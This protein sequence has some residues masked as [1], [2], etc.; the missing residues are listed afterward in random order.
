[1][2]LSSVA[3]EIANE[4]QKSDPVRDVEFSISPDV[5]ANGDKE[6]LNIALTNLM[7]NAFK[8]TSRHG[9]ARI[10]FGAIAQ[11]GTRVYFVRDDGAGFDMQFAEKMFGAFQRMHSSVEFSGT[12]IGLATVWRIVSRHGGKIWADSEVEKG[13]TFYFTLS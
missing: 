2:N 6:L 9:K 1:M 3:Q 10:E 11:N 8:F 13:A 4:L 12:G 7:Q 5:K